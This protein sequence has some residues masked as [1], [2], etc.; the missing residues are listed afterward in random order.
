MLTDA[1]V[2]AFKPE[3]KLYR[4]AD[5]RG[6]YLEINLAGT[7]RWLVRFRG[8]QERYE[9]I[10][11]YPKMTLRQAR[12]ISESMRAAKTVTGRT[13][14]GVAC[15]F[16]KMQA[17]RRRATYE[18]ERSKELERDIFGEI[19]DLPIAGITAPQILVALRKVEARHVVLT[20]QVFRYGIAAGDCEHDPARDIGPALKAPPPVKHHAC[21]EPGELPALIKAIKGY[22][23]ERGTV[24]GLLLVMHTHVR[25]KEAIEAR[26]EE[27]ELKGEAPLWTIPKSRMKGKEDKRKEHSV[28]LSSEVLTIL[29][30]LKRLAG[31]SPYLFPSPTNPLR[32]ISNNTL[33]FSL[34]RLGYRSKMTGHGFR[35]LASTILNDH[36]ERGLIPWSSDTIELCLAH[37]LP[38]G[39]VRQAYNRGQLM[40]Q[41]R[42]LMVYWSQFLTAQEAAAIL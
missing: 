27:F 29:T 23:G 30:E 40:E 17:P 14:K 37:E 8:T 26:W 12:E 34:Y 24:L 39:A 1:Q 10:G 35:A 5:G 18:K 3:S 42:Q 4:R 36:R 38:G 13:F 6:L 11:E 7:K 25:T 31:S 41:R 33:L 15:E 9:A 22:Q 16:L 28:P 21:I 19:G 32:P 20:S 2:R